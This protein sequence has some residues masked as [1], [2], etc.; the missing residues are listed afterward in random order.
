M[1]SN[2]DATGS[3]KSFLAQK[4]VEE[5]RKLTGNDSSIKGCAPTGM[6]K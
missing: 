3:G 6:T 5:V 2:L 1:S 4:L